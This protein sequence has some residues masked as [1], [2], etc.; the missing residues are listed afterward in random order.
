MGKPCKL[1]PNKENSVGVRR[2]FDP[3]FKREAVQNRLASGKSAEVM[4]KESWLLPSTGLYDFTFHVFD[5]EVDPF[6]IKVIL[7]P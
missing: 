1:K 6:G 4:A 5:A 2:K 7:P 3:T